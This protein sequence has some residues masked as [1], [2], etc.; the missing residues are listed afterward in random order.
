MATCEAA[1][2]PLPPEL[3][4][5]LSVPS[6]GSDESRRRRRQ[7][8][9]NDA[10][11]SLLLPPRRGWP[12]LNHLPRHLI[13]CFFFLSL[14]LS[15]FAVSAGEGESYIRGRPE[16]TPAIGKKEGEGKKERVLL[17]RPH[18]IHPLLK[19]GIRGLGLF[20]TR[21]SVLHDL[22][23]LSAFAIGT[24]LK[25]VI[26]GGAGIFAKEYLQA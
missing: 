6:L 8:W 16:S 3:R 17:W 11:L 13:H 18:S 9:L 26:T 24:R 12:P 4:E 19:P 22:G 25:I 21:I 1:P 2:P 23:N 15:Y 10:D 7:W 14:S 5:R 20:I